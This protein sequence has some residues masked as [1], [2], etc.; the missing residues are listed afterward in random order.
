MSR[1][2][3]A[4]M[5]VDGQRRSRSGRA[6]EMIQA[7]WRP[8][9]R[10][11]TFLILVFCFASSIRCQAPTKKNV[12]IL[13]EVGLSHSLT[14]VITQQIVGGVEE[15]E[16]RHVEFYSESLDLLSFP[17]KP[18]P[19]EI[20]AWLAK[21]YS[22]GRLD[23]IVAIGPDVV[24]FLEKRK[25]SLFKDV[26]IV[27][28]GSS[29]DQAGNPVL[30]SRFTGTWEKREPV[31]TVQ[32]ALRLFPE[33]K[34]VFVV[35][36]NANFDKFILERTKKSLAQI[37]SQRQF[38][39]LTDLRM[40]QLLQ[41]LEHLP[42]H[43]VV[44]F[45][46]YFQDVEGNTFVNATKALP[47]IAAAA[48]VPVFGMSDTYL[49]HGIVGGAL[50]SF[51]QQGKTTAKIVSQ[52]IDDK[53]PEE[54]PIQTISSQ[55]MFDWK[56][57]RRWEIAENVLPASSIVLFREPTLWERTRWMWIA[58]LLIILSLAAL[59]TYLQYSRKQLQLARERKMQLSGLLINAEEKERSRVAN[60]LHDDFSQRLAVMALK[61]ENISELIAPLSPD[62]EKQL[63]EVLNATAELGADLHSLSH[64]L[65][66][67]TLQSLGLTPAVSAL[68]K[69]FSVQECVKTEFR[70]E[71][72]PGSVLPD[73]ALCAFRIVQEGLRN[74][75][76]HSG[77]SAARV[78]LHKSDG[79]LIV[80]VQDNGHG[81]DYESTREKAGL[82]LRSMEERAWL[83]GGKF[84]VSSTPGTGTTIEADIPLNPSNA[85]ETE[86]SA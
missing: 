1:S 31:Q 79:N 81:F 67:S 11:T 58:A 30:D 20:A 86:T 18:T 49:G 17:D 55:Y 64:R 5:E 39:Y 41:Q 83:L 45:L 52:L 33:T 3:V 27:I 68:C 60:E 78:T 73:V 36:G 43:S 72:V 13:S 10:G 82:G 84:V 53:K 77:A 50:M 4:H 12:L 62:G 51:Q 21:K 76:K 23:V 2:P 35:S 75:K 56:E 37:E 69:E 15:T 70:A 71:N 38:T 28:C 7:L 34:H 26:P 6:P 74:V 44:F 25:E 61:L 19:E 32:L 8:L 57:L 9:V 59:A 80:S 42:E 16:G 47:M 40:G 14:S 29:E 66:S 24:R 48:K 63:R 46:S 22:N 54:I 65:H 85:T